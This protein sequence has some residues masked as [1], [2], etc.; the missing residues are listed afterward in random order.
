MLWPRSHLFFAALFLSTGLALLVYIISGV[1][2]LAAAI[3]VGLIAAIIGKIAWQR[4]TT[5]DHVYLGRSLRAG[6][7]AGILATLA[8][9]LSRFLLIRITGIMFW[10]FDIFN[11]FG[12][13][14]IGSGGPS[15]LITVVGVVY[16]LANGVGFAIAFT[17]AF[18]RRGV[19][20]GIVWAL[21]LELLMVS[22][23]PGWLGLKAL[24]EF[25]QVSVFGHLV[26]GSVLG[27]TAR[28]LLQSDRRDI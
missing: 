11:I 8:Y 2:L 22:V 1:S 14:L 17:I 4:S 15:E 5:S 24:D 3:L 6:I 21:I 23:Y 18:G 28:R 7:V 25:V 10:P 12:R 19:L 27:F 16:H 13:A 9:D 26:Y 20:A